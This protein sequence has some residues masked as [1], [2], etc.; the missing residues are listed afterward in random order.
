MSDSLRPMDCTPPGSSVHAIFQARILECTHPSPGD[1]PD[2]GVELR[3]PELQADSVLY[4]LP[5]NKVPNK[6]INGK[7]IEALLSEFLADK[8]HCE[9]ILLSLIPGIFG[10]HILKV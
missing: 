6:V 5:G 7:F 8:I 10:K 1:L 2:P 9:F 4:E 3:S